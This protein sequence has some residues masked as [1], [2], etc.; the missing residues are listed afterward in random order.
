MI[1]RAQARASDMIRRAQARASDMIRR[2]SRKRSWVGVVSAAW[3]VT[4][5]H[6]AAAPGRGLEAP[7]AQRPAHVACGEQLE[8]LVRVASGL[9]P[10]PG[11]QSERALRGFA[12]R[13]C[14]DGIAMA[15]PARLCTPLFV[16]NVRPRD[17][18]SL[19][20]R[21][22]MVVPVALARGR[23]D[24]D[25]RF[26]GGSDHADGGIIVGSESA[27]PVELHLQPGAIHARA[28]AARSASL[29]VHV[30]GPG[31]A[32]S[33]G[34]AEYFPRY[35]DD[36]TLGSGSV[37]LIHLPA[38]ASARIVPASG[39]LAVPR[40]ARVEARADAVEGTVEAGGALAFVLDDARGARVFWWFSPDHGAEGART[41]ARF[42]A[43]GRARVDAV[44][45]D[46]Q[47]RGVV[48]PSSIEVRPRVPGSCAV[49]AG[50]A[51]G[52]PPGAWPSLLLAALSWKLGARGRARWGGALRRGPVDG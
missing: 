7:T 17:P 21:M 33:G 38:G 48:Y 40:S 29:R 28:P 47:G 9:T 2:A 12:A 19:L 4:H 39:P 30:G 34:R 10:P 50:D 14:A 45:I 26:P 11:I 51:P 32:V 3:L 46:A 52:T 49:A 20:Y 16:R 23:Y 31:I 43:P 42:L 15:A 25:V 35:R 44:V 22:Q 5:G 41:R 36:G 27:P 24:L 8:L 13:L 1:R 37:A 6:V 18:H